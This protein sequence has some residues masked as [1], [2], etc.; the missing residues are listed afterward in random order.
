VSSWVMHDLGLSGPGMGHSVTCST[1]L[2]SL[3]NGMAWLRSGMA[4]RF[5]AGGT[6]APLTPFT[7][8][9]M[10]A[11]KVTA[12]GTGDGFPCKPLAI[13]VQPGEGMVLGEGAAMFLLEADTSLNGRSALAVIESVGLAS[14]HPSGFTAMS[15]EGDCLKRAMESA[16][17]QAYGL[18]IDLIILHAPG[19]GKGD[20]AE[21]A[22]IQHV[23]GQNTPAIYMPKWQ[24]GHLLGA[25]A[26]LSLA[27]AI[28]ILHGH[29][30]P[31]SPY[32][33]LSTLNAAPGN[34]VKRIMV[35]AAGFG[36]NAGSVIVSCEG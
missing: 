23:F 18:Q 30:I 21:L 20:R 1:T 15:P 27:M 32:P 4:S 25:S 9:Q 5:I 16:L 10:S 26:G 19:T 24:T 2:Q 36:G 31:D 35:N 33:T 8:A 11:L 28:N 13:S 22:A 6:E 29:A 34:A 12:K 3:A 14:E 17:D 7:L